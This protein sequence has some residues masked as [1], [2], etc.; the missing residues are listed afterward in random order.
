M[1]KK[2]M[3]PC[4]RGCDSDLDL[5]HL[6]IHKLVCEFLHRDFVCLNVLAV[7]ENL[8]PVWT[9]CYMFI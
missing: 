2:A 6:K 1:E 3:K 5:V 9:K 8:C 4:G 7:N